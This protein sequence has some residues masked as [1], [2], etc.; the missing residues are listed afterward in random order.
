MF[1]EWADV[2]K[3]QVRVWL[4][5]SAVAVNG[6][7]VTQ[8]NHP[9]KPGDVVEV[10]TDRNAAPQSV[11][12]GAR[13]GKI[14]IRHEDDA[15]LV[16]EKPSGLLSI[17]N[18]EEREKTVYWL[19]NEY[20]REKAGRTARERERVWIVHRLDRETS[21]LMVFAK[22]EKA[23]RTLQDDWERV[24]KQ[25]FAVV[26]AAPPPAPQ[27]PAE[28]TGTFESYLDESNPYRVK[29][30]KPSPRTRH[31]LTH[32][33]VL[34]RKG[35]RALLELTLRTGRRH[36]IRV[37]L[38]EAGWSILG[39]PKYGHAADKARRLALHSCTLRFR[40]PVTEERM[41]FS[42]PLPP[43]LKGMLGGALPGEKAKPAAETDKTS[44]SKGQNTA[45]EVNAPSPAS[46][47]PERPPRKRVARGDETAQAKRRGKGKR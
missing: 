6:K 1:A 16:I 4:K 27:P 3:K 47:P 20:L 31:A 11:L 18:E 38:S 15:I 19:L 32:Y 26:E 23:K 21:G 22:T 35:I 34:H 5:N 36:Q 12:Q 13:G 8:Y 10:R 45:V 44:Q 37:H 30:A 24:D 29:T 14:T 7:A 33:K 17:A 39:D 25:Y 46:P 41:E 28:D 2:K 40:H 9:L 42:T 43:E